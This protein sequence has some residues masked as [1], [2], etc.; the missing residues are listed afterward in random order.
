MRITKRRLSLLVGGLGAAGA[1]T[2]LSLGATSAL[3]TSTAG[4]QHDT[5]TSGTVTLTSNAPVHWDITNLMPGTTNQQ[6]D[7]T[8]AYDLTYSG[9]ADAFVAVAVHVKGTAANACS[10]YAADTTGL[11]TSDLVTNCTGTGEMPM[12]N[13]DG[14]GTV[15][16]NVS[17][18]NGN[19]ASP[20]L[21]TS[22]ILTASGGATCGIDTYGKAYCEATVDN[23]ML[24]F[25]S[26]NGTSVADSHLVWTNGT[27]DSVYFLVG[28]PLNAPNTYQGST[29]AIDLTGHAVQFINNNTT[30]G[31]VDEAP[32][33]TLPATVFGA[34]PVPKS[35]S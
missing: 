1:A 5:I 22:Q 20:L 15:V 9:S 16:L 11:S 26:F 4:P 30:H 24:P 2:V 10:Y 35:W 29:V 6:T 33:T 14:L 23:L 19:T 25:G 3:Y 8:K 17:P 27:T 34:V 32:D 18:Q 13:G 28:L 12:F 31:A 7:R 21:N